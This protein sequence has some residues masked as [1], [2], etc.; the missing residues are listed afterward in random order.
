MSYEDA[1]N[2]A[3]QAAYATRAVAQTTDD[4]AHKGL[5]KAVALIAD[6]LAEMSMQHHRQF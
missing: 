4:D 6:T 1:A 3:A 5:A 2:K